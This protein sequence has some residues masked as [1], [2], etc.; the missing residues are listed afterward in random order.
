MISEILKT[1][2]GMT[3]TMIAIFKALMSTHFM[4]GPVTGIKFKFQA[5]QWACSYIF[6]PCIFTPKVLIIPI[7]GWSPHCKCCWHFQY[8]TRPVA[9]KLGHAVT[10]KEYI[11]IMHSYHRMIKVSSCNSYAFDGESKYMIACL[12]NLTHLN[13]Q[14]L[15]HFCCKRSLFGKQ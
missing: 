7:I 12:T 1:R 3:S 11:N 4:T 13:Q 8:T 6:K 14:F 9:P 5:P 15:F 10:P 2:F